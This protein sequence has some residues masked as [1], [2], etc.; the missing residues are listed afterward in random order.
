MAEEEEEEEEEEQST[1][2]TTSSSSSSSSS[3]SMLI[4]RLMSKRRTWACLF[5][6]VYTV[7]LTS[8][9][10]ILKSIL[11]WYE[12]TTSSSSALY[13]SVAL[14]ALFGL[15]AM[16]A[17]LA[18]AVP[19]TMVSWITVLVLLAFCGKPRT[20]LVVE[21]KK[22]TAEIVVFVVKILIKEGNVVAAICAVLGY[23]ALFRRNR[24][25]VV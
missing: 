18:V 14:G 23:F 4:I 16:A 5:I 25:D 21:G 11:S 15:L 19:A 13:A 7:L 20:A 12:T 2:P 24:D 22:L 6:V 1:S 17:A 3:S 8:S 10:N 9:W